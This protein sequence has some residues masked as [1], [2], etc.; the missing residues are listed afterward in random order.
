M[1][2]ALSMTNRKVFLMKELK[3][4]GAGTM[5]LVGAFI[6][7]ASLIMSIGFASTGD[8]RMMFAPLTALCAVGFSRIAYLCFGWF[9]KNWKVRY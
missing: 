6:A 3:L 1:N 2:W 4:L 8:F 9:T 7:L 5:T